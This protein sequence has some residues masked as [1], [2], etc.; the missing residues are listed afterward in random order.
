MANFIKIFVIVFLVFI[1][2]YQLSILLCQSST[3]SYHESFRQQHQSDTIFV[4]IANY[5]DNDCKNTLKHLYKM[6]KNP[7]KI[8]VGVLSQYKNMD[9]SCEVKDLKYPYNVRY[10]NVVEHQARGPLFARI[11]IIDYLFNGE[12]YFL[13]IDAHTRFAKNWDYDA[14]KQLNYLKRQGIARPILS[15]YPLT[16]DDYKNNKKDTTVICNIVEGDKIPTVLGAATLNENN[17]RQSYFVSGGCTFTFGKFVE[18]IK[19]DPRLM[20]IFGGEE[21]LFSILAYTHGWDIYSYPHNLFFHDY[22]HTKPQWFKDNSNKKDFSKD[23]ANSTKI[24]QELLTNE[25]Y[26]TKYKL[27]TVRSLTD[28]YKTIGWKLEGNKLEDHWNE[29][30]NKL[31]TDTRVIK[32]K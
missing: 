13:M 18:D 29:K 21:L 8:Y 31:C 6:A 15:T 19:L 28:F 32:Y 24:L 23:Q 25:K 14:K 27:G 20:H 2:V 30:K 5:R 9:E 12:K 4:S 16:Y 22:G 3:H 26:E 7:E 17:F 11:N 10:M 1:L